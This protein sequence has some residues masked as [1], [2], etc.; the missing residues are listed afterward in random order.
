VVHVVDRTTIP[1]NSS[2]H[3]HQPTTTTTT[4]T[5]TSSSSSS[6]SSSLLHHYHT[7]VGSFDR[8]ECPNTT[9]THTHLDPKS[10]ST[11][12]A[13]EQTVIDKQEGWWCTPRESG[14]GAEVCVGG[15][16]HV[17]Q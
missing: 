17:L 12:G 9:N 15:P 4:T 7:P 3:H 10:K 5:T 16:K 2:L 1:T 13:L 6:S 11:G 8:P 14:E